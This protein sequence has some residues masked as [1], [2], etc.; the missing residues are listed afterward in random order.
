M[1]TNTNGVYLVEITNINTSETEHTY[2]G[3]LKDMIQCMEKHK[4]D[5]D[6]SRSLVGPNCCWYESATKPVTGEI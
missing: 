5:A 3:S 4:N 6:M 2:Q 1:S